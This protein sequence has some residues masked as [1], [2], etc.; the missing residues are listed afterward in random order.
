MPK[1]NLSILKPKHY[2]SMKK[3]LKTVLSNTDG[4]PWSSTDDYKCDKSNYLCKAIF[5]LLNKHRRTNFVCPC[6]QYNRK[7]V[8]KTIKEILNER[9][10]N[11]RS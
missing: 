6:H 10:K 3:W 9:N 7:Y 1:R 8:T 2:K 5:P 4:C 11:P